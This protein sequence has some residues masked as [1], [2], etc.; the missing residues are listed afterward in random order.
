[1]E[2]DFTVSGTTV[3]RSKP[4]VLPDLCIELREPTAVLASTMSREQLAKIIGSAL[5][6]GVVGLTD[7]LEHDVADAIFAAGF[8]RPTD[9][10]VRKALTKLAGSFFVGER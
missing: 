6:G 10:A 1:Q 9:G 7:K 4:A 5:R 8:R 2:P 3:V